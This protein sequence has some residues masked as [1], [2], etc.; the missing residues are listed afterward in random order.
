[1]NTML[2]FSCS[3]Q[4]VKVAG[5]PP[6]TPASHQL[7]SAAHCLFSGT[8]SATP[9]KEIFDAQLHTILTGEVGGSNVVNAYFAPK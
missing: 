2:L 7:E 3:W 6:S 1:M 8:L 5:K 4:R 9:A